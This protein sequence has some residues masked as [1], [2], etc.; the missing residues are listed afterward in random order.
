M[1]ASPRSECGLWVY[2]VCGKS[3]VGCCSFFPL[4][5]ATVLSAL[6]K[7]ANP[8]LVCTLHKLTQGRASG[9]SPL[10]PKVCI[11]QLRCTNKNRAAH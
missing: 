10:G 6:Y 1:A 2:D 8:S 11:V 7:M 3:G 9:T 4:Y 5:K